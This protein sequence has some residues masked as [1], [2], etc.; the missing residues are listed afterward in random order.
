MLQHGKSCDSISCDDGT[1]T[2]ATAFPTAGS[3][4][5]LKKINTEIFL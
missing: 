2:R 3:K 1:A 5:I 4:V